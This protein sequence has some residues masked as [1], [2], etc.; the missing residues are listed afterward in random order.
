[1]VLKWRTEAELWV[2][3]CHF[4]CK[5]TAVHNKVR[6]E[7][8]RM[9]QDLSLLTLCKFTVHKLKLCFACCLY[10]VSVVYTIIIQVPIVQG[11]QSGI[12]KYIYSQLLFI[13]YPEASKWLFKAPKSFTQE[14]FYPAVAVSLQRT[15][16]HRPRNSFSDW[17]WRIAT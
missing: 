11:M 14:Y 7:Y 13:P 17:C 5:L 10:C 8:N 12:Y 15:P 3:L 9:S 4:W 2:G 16:T 6:Q 1:M